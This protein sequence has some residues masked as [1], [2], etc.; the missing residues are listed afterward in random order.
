MN[1][2]NPKTNRTPLTEPEMEKL[3]HLQHQC[4]NKWKFISVQFQGRCV[5]LLRLSYKEIHAQ[6]SRAMCSVILQNCSDSQE[7]FFLPP[8]TIQKGAPERAPGIRFIEIL[9]RHQ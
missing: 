2:L 1:V 4:G 5:M 6:F 7:R 8:E 3:L 9:Q